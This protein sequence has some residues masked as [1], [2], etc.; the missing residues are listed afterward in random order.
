MR[1]FR[2]IGPGAVIAAAFIGPG[3]VT[4][5]TLAGAQFGYTLVWAITFATLA[6]IA[7]QE[8]SARLGVVARTDLGGVVRQ[9]LHGVARAL[10]AALVVSAIVVGN[11][12]YQTGNLLGAA[13]GL[14]GLSGVE[15]SLFAPA[16]GLVAFALLWT[17]SY[18][19]LERALVTLVAVMG[20]VF[21]ATALAVASSWG[22][23]ASGAV[24]PALP[25]G[26]NHLALALVGTTVVPYNLFLH[27]SAA[28]QRWQGASD[29]GFARVD[30][31]VSVGL[32]GVISAAILVTAAGLPTGTRIHSAIEMAGA[33]EPTLG[34]WARSFF[35]LGLFAA[36]LSSAITAPMAAAY[37]TAGAL[38][39][40]SDLRSAKARGVWGLVVL[41]GTVVAFAG[42]APVPAIVF[43]Q[44][45]NG[46]L[47]PLIVAFL[48]WAV[49]DRTL[50][51]RH[52]NGW[53]ANL[54]GFAALAVALA[55]GGRLLWQAFSP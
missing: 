50:L 36:G 31:A 41:A 52:A 10:A 46:L 29:L 26:S 54:V 17:G 11:A 22:D 47:L 23:I 32:G 20:V 2:G 28:R 1:R 18:G 6:T 53:V 24:R 27:A 15:S 7:L 35:S 30:T 14:A 8:M 19:L 39:W 40:S 34:T 37:A 16:V 9:R 55:L 51:G 4:T 33:L 49:N 21:L 38:G 48:L 44:A 13:L 12:A 42:P 25:A 5:A 3:T 43:A 45:A